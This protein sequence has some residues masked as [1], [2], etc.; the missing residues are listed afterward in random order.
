MLQ[1]ADTIG[2]FQVESRAQM[3]TLPRLRPECFYDLVVQVAIIR[4]GPIV[5]DMVHPYLRAPRGARADHG[6]PPRSRAD[7]ATHARG[8]ALP[9]AAAPHGDG[10]RGL[11]RRRGGGAAPRLRLQALGA[12]MRGGGGEAPRRHGA[13]GHLGRGGRGHHPL[14]HRLCALW[15]PGV[16]GGRDAR[17]R[18][19]DRPPGEDR[20]RRERPRAPHAHPRLRYGSEAPKAPGRSRP[21]R[22]GPGWC[23]ASA[24]RWVESCWPRRSICCSLSTAG[25]RS[26]ACV[27]AIT[28]RRP[29][30][31][32][33]QG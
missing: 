10:H 16:R 24:P 9:G 3:A 32:P 28:S 23:I 18:R 5:G 7:P 2:V 1:H 11:H 13:P 33:C 17:H 12:G 22:V 19:G 20:G 26:E 15:L 4:P 14:H 6:A 31:Y 29:G 21:P 25:S 27:L 30:P 8:A